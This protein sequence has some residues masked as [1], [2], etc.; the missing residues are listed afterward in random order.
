MDYE[1]NKGTLLKET[2]IQERTEEQSSDQTGQKRIRVY[3]DERNLKTSYANGCQTTATTEEI[4]LDFGLNH[5]QLPGQQGGEP[6][7]VFHADKRIIM[8]YYSAK[9]LTITLSQIIR[10]HE[11]EFGELELNAKKRRTGPT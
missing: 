4:L 7:I 8:N 9:R 3:T 2:P 11:Q 6:R 1:N 5:V 10:R